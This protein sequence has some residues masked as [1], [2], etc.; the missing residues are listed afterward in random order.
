MQT[1]SA[2]DSLREN[3]APPNPI[4][5]CA[6]TFRFNSTDYQRKV[7]LDPSVHLPTMVPT[8]RKDNHYQLKNTLDSTHSPGERNSSRCSQP[9]PE[10]CSSGTDLYYGH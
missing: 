8:E 2:L 9:P 10:Q 6:K 1:N 3:L 5:F 4:E 7:L